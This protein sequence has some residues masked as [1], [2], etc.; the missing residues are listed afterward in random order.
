MNCGSCFVAILSWIRTG[1]IASAMIESTAEQKDQTLEDAVSRNATKIDDRCSE[2][3]KLKEQILCLESPEFA[4]EFEENP[5]IA[6]Q[7]IES[8]VRAFESPSE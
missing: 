3:A 8:I 2:I 5:Q 7:N 1:T 6:G 4:A